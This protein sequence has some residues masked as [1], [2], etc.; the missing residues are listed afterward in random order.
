MLE[1]KRQNGR[2][3]KE[4]A[5]RMAKTAENGL[6]KKWLGLSCEI[7]HVRMEALGEDD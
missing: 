1:Q 5:R 2:E 6:E 4:E 3:I 7:T